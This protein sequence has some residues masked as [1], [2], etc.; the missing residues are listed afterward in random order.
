VKFEAKQDDWCTYH[1]F[2]AMYDGIYAAMVKSGVAIE[3]P[4]EV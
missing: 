4:S 2:I 3:L 1:N